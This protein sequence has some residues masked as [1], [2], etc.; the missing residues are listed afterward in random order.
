MLPSVR[1]RPPTSNG[2]DKMRSIEFYLNAWDGQRLSLDVRQD[3]T[4]EE[5]WFDADRPFELDGDALA[6]ALSTLCGTKFERIRFDFEVSTTIAEEISSWTQSEVEVENEDPESEQFARNGSRVVLNFSGGFDSL[7]ATYL[8]PARTELVSLDFGGRFARERQFFKHFDSRIISTNLTTTSLRRNS[9]SFMGIGPLLLAR[10]LDARYF[11]FGSIIEASGLQVRRPV[12]RNFTFPPFRIAGF[13]NAAPVAGI[14][15]AGTVKILQTFCP[16]LIRPSLES[17]ASPGEEK[18]YRKIALARAVSSIYGA[19]IDLPELPHNP[20]I[21]FSFG[22]NLTVD[23]TALFFASVGFSHFANS[24][25]RGAPELGEL[26]LKSRDLNFM[27]KVDQNFY[28][29]YPQ[30]LKCALDSSL[31]VADLPCYDPSDFDSVERVRQALSAW[32]PSL[33]KC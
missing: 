31:A 7:A 25:V 32:H 27:L 2:S 20:K 12:E 1:L 28:N 6:T 14:S 30:D 8:L 9:W 24:I 26:G 33:R 19:D 11:A 18:F 4:S 21:H 16:E 22:D 10:E 13:E 5:L 29:S 15:E 17:L 23:L 3:G